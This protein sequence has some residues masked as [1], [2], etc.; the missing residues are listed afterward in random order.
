MKNDKHARRAV[1]LMLLLGL[2]LLEGC[3][4]GAERDEGVG[5]ENDASTAQAGSIV[6]LD[7]NQVELANIQSVPVR[8]GSMPVEL[9]LNGE[10][11]FDGAHL[12]SLTPRVSG[13]V[14]EVLK[15]VGSLV[16]EGDVLVVLHSRELAEAKSGYL[17]AQQRMQLEQGR[18]ERLEKLWKEKIAA[19]QDYLDARQALAEAKI[20]F[21]TAGQALF[22]LGLGP[23]EV[24]ALPEAD[25]SLLS[26]Y[27]VRAPFGGTLVD[28]YIAQGEQVNA[29]TPLFRLT[30]VTAV[31]VNAHVYE[32]DVARVALGQIGRV[33]VH[34]YPDRLFIGRVIWI[35]D[36][37]DPESRTLQVRLEVSNPER[38]LKAGLFAEVRLQVGE[39]QK[40][41][42]MPPEA[43]Q[44]EPGSTFVFVAQ[45]AGSYERRPVTTGLQT[46]DA[47]EIL[48]GLTDGDRVITNG[49][50]ILKSEM[51]KES[52]GDDD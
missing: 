49:A 36:A 17:A 23:E 7:P 47:V 16:A 6:H 39:R 52:F 48:A 9:Q 15:T 42:T 3:G 38:L 26:C 31:W 41:L 40:V 27:E 29:D 30:P 11:V 46:D 14:Q 10:V 21:Q 1:P 24:K 19:E 20:E 4:Q 22:V 13:S 51:E 43:L 8:R 50:F 32:E 45:D 35:A 18:F 28:Q 5:G 34:A 37:M 33:D 25:P 12:V 2:L 44:R